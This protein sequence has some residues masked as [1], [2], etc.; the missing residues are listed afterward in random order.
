M[1]V[2][3][4]VSLTHIA[5]TSSFAVIQTLREHRN[6]HRELKY[7]LTTVE[8]ASDELLANISSL[9]ESLGVSLEPSHFLKNILKRVRKVCDEFSSF[10]DEFKS[11]SSAV[12]F[13]KAPRWA[14][15]LQ[16]LLDKIEVY[17]LMLNNLGSTTTDVSKKHAQDSAHA[18]FEMLMSRSTDENV[19][20]WLKVEMQ[21]HENKIA[22][23]ETEQSAIDLTEMEI[24]RRDPMR[25]LLSFESRSTNYFLFGK[26]YY[27]GMEVKGKY[28]QDF[29]TRSFGSRILFGRT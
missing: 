7:I 8:E 17:D 14:A 25:E 12:A 9:K 27:E 1:S 13:F 26:L 16:D 15:N 2:V 10:Q 5:V 24:G 23:G 22:L 21:T 20:K 18:F 28:L 4:I 6:W 11:T 29:S 19:M 3:D